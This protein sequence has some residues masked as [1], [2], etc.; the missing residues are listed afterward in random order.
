MATT[1]STPTSTATVTSDGDQPDLS[2]II[3]TMIDELAEIDS[4]QKLREQAADSALDVE[5][6]FRT[7]AGICRA[8]NAGIQ[9][10]RADKLVFIDDDADPCENYLE[11]MATRLEDEE[12]V[13]GRVEHPGDGLYKDLAEHYPTGD[14]PDP[15]ADTIVGCNMAFRREVFET[16]GYFDEDLE[17]GHDETELLD[18]AREEFQVFYDPEIAVEHSYAES[19]IDL[20]KK[21]WRIGPADVTYATKS[22]S[23]SDENGGVLRTLLAPEQYV[24]ETVRGTAVK[25]VGR[26]LRNASIGLEIG[27]RIKSMPHGTPSREW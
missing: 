24:H 2:V 3:V 26:V 27:R 15:D 21:W 16:V 22:A 7:D 12:I 5:F 20:W 13:A 6:I 14:E 25:S 11:R 1:Q 18:R 19:A 9:R 8:R 4:Y 23:A 10:A 17:W